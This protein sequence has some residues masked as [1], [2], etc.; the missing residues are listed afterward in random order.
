MRTAA[1]TYRRSLGARLDSLLATRFAAQQA[2]RRIAAPADLPLRLEHLVHGL[3]PTC[4]WR[5]YRAA[6]RTFFAVARPPAAAQQPQGGGA[7]EAYFLDDDARVYSAAV[8]EYDPK[9]GWWL[10]SVL[11]LAYDCEHGWWLSALTAPAARDANDVSVQAWR[12]PRGG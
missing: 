9:H 12:Y 8:W 4:V 11:S 3:A 6:E 10:D 7:L 5:A 1:I 2:G